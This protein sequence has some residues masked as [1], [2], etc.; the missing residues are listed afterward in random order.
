VKIIGVQPAKGSSIPGIKRVETRPKW[1]PLVHID[2]IVDVTRDEAV[3]SVI[4]IARKEGLLVGLSS[5]ATYMGF[6][7]IRRKYGKGVYILVFPDDIFKYIEIFQKIM[8]PP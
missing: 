6:R 4:E 5:G 1:L 3:E 8:K 2:E 7:K